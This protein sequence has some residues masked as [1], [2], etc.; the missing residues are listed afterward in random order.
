MKLGPLPDHNEKRGLQGEV[1]LQTRP[2]L[3]AFLDAGR[4]RESIE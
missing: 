1:W 3:V 4:M 2:N